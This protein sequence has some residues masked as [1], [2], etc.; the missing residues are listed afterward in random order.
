MCWN[1]Y[2]DRKL[3]VENEADV[4]KMLWCLWTGG[5]QRTA[6]TRLS[7]VSSTSD[8]INLVASVSIGISDR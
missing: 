3:L 4:R 6:S 1:A 7:F 5:N 8:D 2:D